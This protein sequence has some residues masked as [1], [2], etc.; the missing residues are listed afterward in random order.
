MRGEK[1]FLESHSHDL[2]VDITVNFKKN[3]LV[4]G[5]QKNKIDI[6]KDFKL[7]NIPFSLF[8]IALLK[9]QTYFSKSLIRTFVYMHV[10]VCRYV[11]TTAGENG[12]EFGT[13]SP[14][15]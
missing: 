11:H 6:L 9:C 13:G 2:C 1:Q 15:A 5:W 3:V 4:S 7:C 14:E 10:S 8:S 12:P